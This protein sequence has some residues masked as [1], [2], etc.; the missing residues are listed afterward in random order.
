[1]YAGYIAIMW[2][3]LLYHF[4]NSKYIEFLNSN[5]QKL[6]QIIVSQWKVFE[7]FT[8]SAEPIMNYASTQKTYGMNNTYGWFVVLL[9][10]CS[11]FEIFYCL[12]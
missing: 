3:V 6:Q 12:F 5:N 8:G 10:L 1:M 7:T 2:S 4:K 9:F 11:F